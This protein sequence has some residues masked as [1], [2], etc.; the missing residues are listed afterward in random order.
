MQW[1][2]RSVS[3]NISGLPPAAAATIASRIATSIASPPCSRSRQREP[4]SHE[5]CVGCA[6]AHQPSRSFKSRCAEAHPTPFLSSWLHLLSPR[7]KEN[8]LA[9]AARLQNR[10]GDAK[11]LD[12][13]GQTRRRGT[14]ALGDVEELVHLAGERGGQGVLGDRDGLLVVAAAVDDEAAVRGLGGLV[15][16]PGDGPGGA[17]E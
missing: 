2:C 14:A 9:R 11:R 13:F 6:L 12:A 1:T 17:E 10:Q 15:A 8:S 16:G 4:R 3:K 5:G 7:R